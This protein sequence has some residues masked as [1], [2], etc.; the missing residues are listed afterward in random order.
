MNNTSNTTSLLIKAISF[1]AEKHRDQRRKDADASPYNNHPIELATL[2]KRQAIDDVVVVCAA[3][4]HD[5]VEDT[6]TTAEELRRTF[7]DAITDVV[8][9]VTDDT[10]LPK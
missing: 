4:L 10:S 6:N 5:T 7:G 9:E 3:L 2:L 1:A 8:L